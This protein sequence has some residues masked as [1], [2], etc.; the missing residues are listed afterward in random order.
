M[1]HVCGWVT[2]LLNASSVNSL[3]VWGYGYFRL[4]LGLLWGYLGVTFGLLRYYFGFTLDFLWG[5]FGL[6][7]GLL[8]TFF[9]VTLDLLW[10]N[11]GLIFFSDYELLWRYIVGYLWP[12]WCYFACYFGLTLG[13]H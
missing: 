11:F 7:L 3:S 4:A 13:L 6:T 5:Y 10:S 8:W 12:T 2:I 9:G 1:S